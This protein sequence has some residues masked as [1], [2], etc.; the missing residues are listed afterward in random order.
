MLE[1][2]SMLQDP[3]WYLASVLPDGSYNP[4]S[5]C[6]ADVDGT[7][8][9]GIGDILFVLDHWGQSGDGDINGS[10]SVDVGGHP[11]NHWCMGCMP[12]KVTHFP[13]FFLLFHEG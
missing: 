3:T 5:P 12:L 9:V 7:G 4:T 10:G 1:W 11:R 6:V 13:C 2:F 8:S